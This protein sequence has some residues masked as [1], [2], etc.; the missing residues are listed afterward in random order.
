MRLPWINGKENHPK[1]F[2]A[3]RIVAADM[4]LM[5]IKIYWNFRDAIQYEL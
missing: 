1:D 3:I 5:I 4:P 2:F